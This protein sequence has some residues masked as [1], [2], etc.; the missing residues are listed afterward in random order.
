MSLSGSSNMM[1]IN[2]EDLL[3]EAVIELYLNVKIR[4]NE[5]PS[6]EDTISSE[7]MNEERDKLREVDAYTILDYIRSSIE[8]LMNLKIEEHEI[9]V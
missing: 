9:E 1:D 3:K 7:V 8:I 2:K 4:G 6:M 5:I